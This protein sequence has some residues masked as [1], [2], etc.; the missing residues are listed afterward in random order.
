MSNKLIFNLLILIYLS[1]IASF[2]Y[3]LNDEKDML[4]ADDW[5]SLKDKRNR[6]NIISLLSLQDCGLSH[7]VRDIGNKIVGGRGLSM[8]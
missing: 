6:S 4:F 1:T 8:N 5:N 3:S 2:A 7:V